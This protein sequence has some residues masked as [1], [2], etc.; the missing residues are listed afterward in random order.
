MILNQ[1]AYGGGSAPAPWAGRPRPSDWPA[2]PAIGDHEFAGLLSVWDVLDGNR[3]ALSVTATGGFTVD[4]GDGTA[5]SWASGA[6]AQHQYDYTDADLGA[7]TSAGCK[8]ALVRV[9]STTPGAAWSA[10]SLQRRH[11]ALSAV[12]ESGWLDV[13]ITGSALSTLEVSK[14]T[15]VVRVGSMRGV[16]IGA[17]GTASLTYAFTYCYS[18]TTP[19]V[20]PAGFNGSL[21]N[22][23]QGCYSLTTPPVLP[24]GFNGSLANA[25][26]YCYSLT[27]PPVLP[28]GFNNSLANAFQN[29]YSLTT[30][31]VLPAG[32]NNSLA[33][34]FQNCYSLTKVSGHSQSFDNASAFSACPSLESGALIGTRVSI[35]YASCNLSPAALNAIYE[36]LADLNA[37]TITGAAGNGA[38]AT[39]ATSVPHRIIVGQRVTVTGITPTGYN[40]TDAIITART[41]T[42]FTVA[43]TQAG[44]YV[45]G[46]AIAAVTGRVVTVTG[47]WGVAS[48]DPTIATNKGWTVTG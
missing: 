13:S 34:A 28:A 17:I 27:T 39:Y 33:N 22:A 29:C 23:F 48:D 45:S 36:G 40:V 6:T 30:P 14:Q 21:A 2:L 24:A 31:P 5:D 1:I 18:L 19:P 41:D 4:W 12:H 7:L 43:S 38:S 37:Y 35:S 42:T 44:T 8:T 47:N 25:F 16:A 3:V 15:Q 10:F 20:L 32:F 46:G 11:S 9:T 26:T